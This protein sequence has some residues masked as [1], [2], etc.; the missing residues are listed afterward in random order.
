MIKNQKQ[1]SLLVN[2]TF[3]IYEKLVPMDNFF[4]VPDEMVN[5][6]ICL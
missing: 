1:M 6:M 3:D 2:K 4:S 5:V